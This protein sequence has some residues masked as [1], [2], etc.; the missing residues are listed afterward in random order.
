MKRFVIKFWWV[1]PCL[2][3]VSYFLPFGLL[4][5]GLLDEDQCF[6][7]DYGFWIIPIFWLASWLILMISKQWRKALF[8]FLLFSPPF[9]MAWGYYYMGKNYNSPEHWNLPY[10]CYTVMEDSLAVDDIPQ[11][12]E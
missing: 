1:F 2:F 7:I 9:F 11:N 10:E 3:A 12:E 8:S 4:G 5:L 6:L